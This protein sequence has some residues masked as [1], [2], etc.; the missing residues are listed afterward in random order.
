MIHPNQSGNKK[1]RKIKQV[2]LFLGSKEPIMV[3]WI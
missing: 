2:Y 3:S 1:L